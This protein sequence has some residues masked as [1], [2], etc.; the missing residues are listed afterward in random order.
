M[1]ASRS[2]PST[3]PMRYVLTAIVLLATGACRMETLYTH[4]QLEDGIG[5][6]APITYSVRVRVDTATNVL[7]WMQDARDAQ[8]VTDR[9]IRT[10]GDSTCDIFDERNWRCELRGV[11]GKVVEAPEMKDG[12]LTRFYWTGTDTYRTRRRIW[13]LTL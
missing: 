3:R 1:P 7:T 10:Y 4:V 2:L 6:K 8:G 13:R 5:M 9:Q 11:D 12:T